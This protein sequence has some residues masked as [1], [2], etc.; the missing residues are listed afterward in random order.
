MSS[1]HYTARDGTKQAVSS[2]SEPLLN[3]VRVEFEVELHQFEVKWGEIEVK[4]SSFEVTAHQIEVTSSHR[5]CLYLGS[6]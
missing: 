2:G 4:Q 6:R 3:R 5:Q 1:A